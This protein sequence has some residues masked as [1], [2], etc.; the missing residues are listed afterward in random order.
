MIT[1]RL[2]VRPVP[3][4]DFLRAYAGPP[5]VAYNTGYAKEGGFPS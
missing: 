2:I 5:S 4:R 1:G 3:V